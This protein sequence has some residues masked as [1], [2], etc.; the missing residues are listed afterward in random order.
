MGPCVW[1]FPLGS[2]LSF[3]IRKCFSKS[4]LL[5]VDNINLYPSL[6]AM[7]SVLLE[8]GCL[9]ICHA[10][11]LWPNGTYGYYGTLIRSW[12][13]TCK[14]HND[15][16][17]WMTFK[18]SFHGHEAANCPH[19]L[20]NCTPLMGIDKNV[21]LCPVNKRYRLS[22]KSINRS[23]CSDGLDNRLALESID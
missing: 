21:H 14:I 5:Q 10:C 16:W 9:S 18:M 3:L 2:I 20:N 17:P 23:I 19:H 4:N 15:L 7:R 12:Y 1:N 11:G 13:R 8:H 6:E 22:S